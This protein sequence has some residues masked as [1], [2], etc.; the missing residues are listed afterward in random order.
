[1][2]K[3]YHFFISRPH[4]MC[5]RTYWQQRLVSK[6]TAT[7]LTHKHHPNN[8]ECVNLEKNCCQMQSSVSAIANWIGESQC[9]LRNINIRALFIGY[10]DEGLLLRQVDPVTIFDAL[11]RN[12][13]LYG[14][15]ISENYPKENKIQYLSQS[16]LK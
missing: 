10:S 6:S 3:Y 15:D 16:L 4:V 14:I 5:I 9:K 11:S 12:S 2:R 1:V 7:V 13:S 8:I